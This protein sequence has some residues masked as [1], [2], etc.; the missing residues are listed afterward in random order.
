LVRLPAI[1]GGRADD[2]RAEAIASG[3]FLAEEALE[4]TLAEL[5]AF[6]TG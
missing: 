6:F 5:H 2:L 3:H 1:R 4:E